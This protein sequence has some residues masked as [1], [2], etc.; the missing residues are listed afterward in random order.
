M[1][2]RVNTHRLRL[3]FKIIARSEK[4]K[5]IIILL[6]APRGNGIPSYGP[7]SVCVRNYHSTYN[8]AFFMFDPT[9]RGSGIPSYG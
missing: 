6:I 9:S 4:E 1:H 7:K 2:R 3:R 5:G 8:I